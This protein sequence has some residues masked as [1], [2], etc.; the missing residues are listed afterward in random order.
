MSDPITDLR[1]DYKPRLLAYL[2]RQDERGLNSAYELGRQAIDQHIGLLDLVTVHSEI[3]LD[4]ASSART[5]DEA[6][7]LARA[8]SGFLLEALA[9]FEM[10]QRGFMTG[11][12]LAGR[13]PAHPE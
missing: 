3:Y 9:A 11:D 6:H 5:L 7:G 13:S 1:R 2:T 4:V 12:G 8:A 10:T